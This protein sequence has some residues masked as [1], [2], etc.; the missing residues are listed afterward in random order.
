MGGKM[1]CIFNINLEI[2]KRWNREKALQSLFLVFNSKENKEDIGRYVFLDEKDV[3]EILF[4]IMKHAEGSEIPNNEDFKILGSKLSI[5]RLQS[6]ENKYTD[7]YVQYNGELS[8]LLLHFYLDQFIAPFDDYLL[9]NYGF[10]S[11]VFKIIYVFLASR[12]IKPFKLL[13]IKNFINNSI[14]QEYSE[15]IYKEVLNYIK[16]FSVEYQD[17]ATNEFH[18]F[19]KS[20]RKKPF[21]NFDKDE[22]FVF[23]Y[24]YRT[25][26]FQ[27]F[28]YLLNDNEDYKK[29]KGNQFE[30]LVAYVMDFSLGDD[31][32]IYQSVKYKDGEMDLFID[33]PKYLILVECK[34]NILYDDYKYTKGSFGV[35]KNLFDIIGKAERQLLRDS[36]MVKNTKDL[37]S[38]GYKINYDNT[39]EVLLLNICFDLPIGFANKESKNRVVTLSLA[40]LIYI[41]DELNNSII[42]ENPRTSDICEYLKLREKALGSATDSE[43]T[44]LI[45]ILYNPHFKTIIENKEITIMNS[46]QSLV[47]FNRLHYL[48]LGCL[49]NPYH[50]DTRFIK[51]KYNGVLRDYVFSS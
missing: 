50:K 30:E 3:Y 44:M 26:V 40:D 27:N 31:C 46:D 45:N 18:N 41:V 14:T 10:T 19:R 21:I 35:E 15:D 2:I 8:D 16:Y 39:K 33:T 43:L 7:E 47:I 9:D 49:Y 48:L 11:Q 29:Y 37:F 51:N 13:D 5:N 32:C 28:H 17:L 36:E 24:T 38:D 25:E 42:S 12:N 23:Y 1:E 34:S 20:L 6:N 22:H 4:L